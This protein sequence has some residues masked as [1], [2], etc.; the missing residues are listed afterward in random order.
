MRPHLG[1]HG[2]Q[3]QVGAGR[4]DIVHRLCAHGGATQLV[5]RFD[6]ATL[7]RLLDE[8]GEA[9]HHHVHA[10]GAAAPAIGHAAF[11]DV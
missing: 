1:G 4:Q 2:V 6:A 3:L 11:L 8:G 5:A 7:K 9:H 10:R